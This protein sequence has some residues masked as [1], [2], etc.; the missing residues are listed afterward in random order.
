MS[1]SAGSQRPALVLFR[2]DLRLADNLALTAAAATGKPV[3]CLYVRDDGVS[4][5][6]E[7]GAARKWWLHHSLTALTASLENL[8]VPLHLRRGEM[9]AIVVS[10]TE[11]SGA[12]LVLWNRRYYPHGRQAD[13]E[14]KAM[15]GEFGIDG[16]SFE[17]HLLH[18]PWR[19]KTGSGG[20][21][22]VFTPLWR[23]LQ[24]EVE[25]REPAPAPDRLKPGPAIASERLADWAL[26]PGKPD[27]AREF[28]SVWTPGEGG[29]QAHL[30]HFINGPIKEY[31]H[32]RDI[33]GD[34][35][36][37]RLSPHLAHGE[38]T[39]AQI[40]SA[41]ASSANG[42]SADAD[43]FRKELGWREFCWHLLFHHGELETRNVNRAFD[44]F[45][46][47]D[48]HRALSAWQRGATGYPIV[49]AGMR[50][51][52]RTGWMHNRVRM[53]V[54]SFLSKHLLI[55]WRAG[56]RWFWDTLV[57]ADPANNPANWQWVAGSG[58]DAAPYFRIFNPILQGEKFDAK[59]GY[60]RTFVPELAK[61]PDRL[62]H[63]PFDADETTLLSAGVKLG[64]NYPVSAVDHVEAR[65]RALDAY[66]RMRGTDDD[67][68]PG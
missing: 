60:V 24:T 4:G 49:D 29:A 11:E 51:L 45:P 16:R 18:E 40:F 54:A 31:G 27:W 34:E 37:S 3:V 57:D 5:A 38:I 25:L 8:G 56:E 66:N 17:G 65:R 20:P 23:A 35:S 39:P 48:D 21:Y 30:D 55:D 28:S 47:R 6:R 64:E 22:K 41:L 12:D 62:I 52:W 2:H 15:L 50:Q 19:L 13:T 43:V 68:D 67:R 63:R 9:Q 32:G 59:G 36:T 58:A 53:I 1:T 14:T 33:P 42:G 61:L 7:I 26:L 46:W 44:A 10:A